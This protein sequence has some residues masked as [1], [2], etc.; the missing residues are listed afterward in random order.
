MVA[1][2]GVG[3]ITLPA[4][5]RFRGGNKETR[6]TFSPAPAL[7]RGGWL[8]TFE[9]GSTVML[10]TPPKKGARPLVSTNDKVHYGQPIFDHQSA[11]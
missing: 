11:Y 9:L 7:K 5:P 10:L 8:A 3:N 4:A 2:W 6:R 1:G